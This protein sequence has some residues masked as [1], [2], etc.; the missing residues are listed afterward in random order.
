M[1]RKASLGDGL[2]AE[3]R[4]RIVR[5]EFLPDIKLPTETAL[6]DLFGVSRTVVREALARLRREGLVYT[7]RGSGTFVTR[8]D[9]A[10][11][12]HPPVLGSVTDVQCFLEMRMSLEGEIAA[13]AAQ[14]RTGAD[15]KTMEATIA[16]LDD[17]RGTGAA[18]DF[19]FHVAVARATGNPFFVS[20]L[21]SLEPQA[22]AGMELG[23]S[24][25]VLFPSERLSLVKVEHSAALDAI[26]NRDANRARQAMRDHIGNFRT[27]LMEGEDAVAPM[28]QKAR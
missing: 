13:L 1:R 26:V 11:L 9:D 3:I 18:E 10:G 14:R 4:D 19:T 23:R 5:G 17:V 8:R 28:R 22:L 27:R 2:H 20:V 24:L 6:G 12:K 21:Q 16:A 15:L 7:R 25:S